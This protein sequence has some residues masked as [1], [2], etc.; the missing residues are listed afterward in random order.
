MTQ[1]CEIFSFL[2]I[3]LSRQ[4]RIC[5]PCVCSYLAT[6]HRMFYCMQDA[7][8]LARLFIVL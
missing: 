8:K 5:N 7:S 4:D 1:E 3:T 2:G 6:G